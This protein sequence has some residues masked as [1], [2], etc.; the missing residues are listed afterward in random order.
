MRHLLLFL[1]ISFGITQLSCA[2]SSTAYRNKNWNPKA[3]KY[4]F[5]TM[6]TW[7]YENELATEEHLRKGEI[8]IYVDEKTGTFLFT[9]EAYGWSG[10]M[11]DFVIADQ[12]GNYII[13][14]TDEVGGKH[15][16]TKKLEHFAEILLQS[17]KIAAD[18]NQYCTPTGKTKIFGKNN[19]GWPTKKGK[20]YILSYQKTSNKNNL[21]LTTEKYSFL[22]VFLF[23]KLDFDA[24]LPVSFDYSM[25]LPNY[26][27][28]LEDVYEWNGKKVTLTFV[29][30]SPTEYYID[31]NQYK[32][33]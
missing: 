28:P 13:G 20:E 33:Q 32:K 3:G 5:S 16:E 1:I 18:F 22:P 21:F 4:Y 12:K 25:I 8:S 9:R 24:S 23:N 11:I 17:K 2:Q 29:S 31:L 6:L 10:E 27:M 7:T 19:Y 26:Q 14:H 15:R 30:S